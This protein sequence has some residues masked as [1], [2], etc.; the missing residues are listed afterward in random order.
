MKRSEGGGARRVV[1]AGVWIKVSGRPTV[2][3]GKKCYRIID[4][5]W[6]YIDKTYESYLEEELQL[7]NLQDRNDMA[8]HPT[9]IT[10]I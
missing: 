2:S 1:S 10:G 5:E 4:G 3:D 9:G 6:T 7:Y 8:P